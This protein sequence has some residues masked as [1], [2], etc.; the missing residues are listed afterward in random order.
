MKPGHVVSVVFLVIVG[1][2]CGYRVVQFNDVLGYYHARHTELWR[3]ID[4]ELVDALAR[5]GL[6][7]QSRYE[8][9]LAQVSGYEL[10][11]ADAKFYRQHA[12]GMKEEL[13]SWISVQTRKARAESNSDFEAVREIVLTAHPRLRTIYQIWVEAKEFSQLRPT[14]GWLGLS[15]EESKKARSRIDQKW[16]E[17]SSFLQKVYP[18]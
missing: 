12:E 1:G 10:A 3:G 4:Y 7:D 18:R 11:G 15:N 9:L 5:E 6:V 16:E 14:P 8:K 17:I 2:M 13:D